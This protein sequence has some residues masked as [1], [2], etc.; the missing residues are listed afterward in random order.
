MIETDCYRE[1]TKKTKIK[2]LSIFSW[3]ILISLTFV[4]WFALVLYAIPIALIL[5]ISL[6][7]LEFFDEDIYQILFKKFDIKADKYYS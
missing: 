4:F 6:F 2:G 5:Y 7:T 1:L 3:I